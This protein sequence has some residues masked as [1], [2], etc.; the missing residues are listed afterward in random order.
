M[1]TG[2]TALSAVIASVMS[3]LAADS[4]FMAAVPGGVWDYVPADPTWP[5]VCL[6]SAREEAVDT[7][8]AGFGSQGRTVSLTL[9]IFS[10]YQGRLEQLSI[11]ASAICVLRNTTLTITGWTH[12]G[13]EYLSAEA[14]S[15]F[16]MGNARAG[17]TTAAFEIRVRD[18]A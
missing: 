3:A 9:T 10:A 2:K 15:L 14:V 5:Y 6:E 17:S 12:A 11:L 8:G 16:E 1:S 18:A 4:T 7:L 13:T